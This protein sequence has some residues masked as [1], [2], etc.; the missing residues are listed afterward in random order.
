MLKWC[1]NILLVVDG[2]VARGYDTDNACVQTLTLRGHT[3]SIS[4]I[5][6]RNDKIVTGSKDNTLIMWNNKEPGIAKRSRVF[7]DQSFRFGDVTNVQNGSVCEVNLLKTA[8]DIVRTG[9][10]ECSPSAHM[11]TL[12][13]HTNAV[14]YVVW[15]K[16]IVSSSTDQT[17]MVW[18]NGIKFRFDFSLL[19]LAL[20]SKAMP[21]KRLINMDSQPH[22]KDEYS[23]GFAPFIAMPTPRVIFYGIGSILGKMDIA[24]GK[25]QP[26]EDT[27]VNSVSELPEPTPVVPEVEFFNEDGSLIV[28]E[29][30]EIQITPERTVD[31]TKWLKKQRKRAYEKKKKRRKRKAE[32]LGLSLPMYM[33]RVVVSQSAK[34]RKQRV[35]RYVRTKL[36]KNRDLVQL[37]VREEY[38]GAS[39][40]WTS[41]EELDLGELDDEGFEDYGGVEIVYDMLTSYSK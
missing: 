35:E 1:G 15:G 33:W 3:N 38:K 19:K 29:I 12:Y 10:F 9:T 22:L 28:N 18:D 8:R 14:E 26:F 6:V 31:A 7:V 39:S 16:Y 20:P 21:Y 5:D 17:I 34:L 41:E 36:L 11:K 13:G 25:R 32:K 4:C 37:D 40:G 24:T 30:N 27:V 2:D 23:S